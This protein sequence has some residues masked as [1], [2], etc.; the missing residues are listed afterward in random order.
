MHRV[1]VKPHPYIPDVLVRADGMIYVPKRRN[2]NGK[3]TFGNLNS[4]GY[5][6]VKI[7][8]IE[9]LVHRLVAETFWLNLNYKPYVDH[10]DR[11]TQN[12]DMWNLRWV[13]PQENSNNAYTN[14]PLG[15][16]RIDFENT[17]DYRKAEWTKL[18]YKNKEAELLKKKLWYQEHKEEY[19]RMR[20]EKRKLNSMS[21]TPSS[22][23]LSI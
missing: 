18:Y 1:K 13:S 3:W 22:G 20:R 21:A 19:N 17:K 23:D 8:G 14:N 9:Y 6:R 7:N 10:I 2:F 12:N 16:R 15:T 5:Y 11:D 4:A